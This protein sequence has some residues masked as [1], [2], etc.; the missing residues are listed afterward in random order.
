MAELTIYYRDGDRV[1]GVAS[2]AVTGGRLVKVSAARADGEN[3]SVAPAGAGE[4]AF[5][6]AGE[7]AAQAAKVPVIRKGVVGLYAASA[8][9]AGQL[10]KV[11]ADGKVAPAGSDPAVG[12]ACDD[13]AQDATGAV[14]LNL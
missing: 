11:A 7:D 3:I 5:G 6:V 1:S 12:I 13:I 2:A 10:V 9:T 4:V 8:V 14:A